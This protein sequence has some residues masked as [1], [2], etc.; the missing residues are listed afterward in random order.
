METQ[1]QKRPKMD[2]R[3]LIIG[4]RDSD[5]TIYGQ[6]MQKRRKRHQ[7]ISI[8]HQNSTQNGEWRKPVEKELSADMRLARKVDLAKVI[9]TSWGSDRTIYGQ[10][11]QKV[12]NWI[13]KRGICYQNL[14]RINQKRKSPKNVPPAH[15]KLSR[16]SW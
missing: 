15:W 5:R 16:A 10:K 4:C 3:K 2:M 11:M 12:R 1:T 14:T 9:T 7:N 6:K 8:C 13:Q